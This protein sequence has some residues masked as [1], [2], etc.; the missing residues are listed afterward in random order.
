MPDLPIPAAGASIPI[1]NPGRA[2]IG[3]DTL[4]ITPLQAALA[5]AALAGDGR[6]PGLRLVESLAGT[7]GQWTTQPA[8]VPAA[9]A[10]VSGDAAVA[11][12]DG[13]PVASRTATFAAT[14]LAG[15]DDSRNAW[16]LGVAP[17]QAPRFVLALVLEGRADTEAAEALGQALL[18]AA[19]ST[20]AGP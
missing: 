15:P 4:T 18:L 12:L 9:A 14:A 5:T 10:G 11:I 17:E 13:W 7:E 8:G 16:L 19:M 20:T 6:L 3:Q 1:D 2:A